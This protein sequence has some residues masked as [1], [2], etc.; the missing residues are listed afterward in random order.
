MLA[1]G[2]QPVAVLLSGDVAISEPDAYAVARPRGGALRRAG[3][4]LPGNKDDGP[5]CAPIRPQ[6]AG[7]SGC[8]L[9]SCRWS[10]DRRLRH[11]DPGQWRAI[12]TSTGC[13]SGSRRTPSRR[14]SWRCTIRP[15][16]WASRRWMRLGSRR[17]AGALDALLHDAPAVLRVTA[18]HVHRAS[19]GTVGGVPACTC[20][21]VSFAS[22]SISRR[23]AS[24]LPPSPRASCCTSSSTATSSRTW[25]RSGPPNA[26]AFPP[27][28]AAWG[29]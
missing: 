13:A 16:A 24:P 17:A 18:G 6:G 22:R 4:V 2:V 28:S 15:T 20:P 29:R 11:A 27:T 7:A 25:C 23:A 3:V 14:Q 21:S 5:R 9:C 12:L 1:L 8:S 19:F 26:A 10:S